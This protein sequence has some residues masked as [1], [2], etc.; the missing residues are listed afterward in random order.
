MDS[1]A[2]VIRKRRENEKSGRAT[3]VSG[4][5]ES[6]TPKTDATLKKGMDYTD[7][8][9][10]AA[11]EKRYGDAAVAGVKAGLTQGKAMGQYVTEKAGNY[12]GE[13]GKKWDE[14]FKK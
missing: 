9:I 7:D 8:Y 12:A 4:G 3:V 2:D 6:D 10:V 11:D 14:T 5:R 1:T 13:L